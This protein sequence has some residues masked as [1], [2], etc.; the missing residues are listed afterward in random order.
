MSLGF[1]E[2]RRR[3]RRR[4]RVILFRWIL[5]LGLILAAGAYAYQTGTRIAERNVISLEQQNTE[6]RGTLED[7]KAQTEAQ[8]QKIAA[9]KATASDWQARYEKDVPTGQI[10]DIFDLVQDKLSNGVAADRL[11]SVIQQIENRRSCDKQQQI[12]RIHVQTPIGSG[13]ASSTSFSNGA[14]SVAVSGASARNAAGNPEAWF[15]PAAPVTV[16]LT[17]PGGKSVEA[18][19]PLPLHPAIVAGEWEYRFTLDAGPRGLVQ[20]FMERCQFP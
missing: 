13:G 9:E 3:R 15:D 12:K 18:T 17:R 1:R 19:G 2:D 14:I 7:L 10:K 6:L 20:I 8:A 16:R 5:A 4:S 11:Q